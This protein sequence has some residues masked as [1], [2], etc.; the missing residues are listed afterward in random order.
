MR[1]PNAWCQR[2]SSTRAGVDAV[3]KAVTDRLGGLDIVVHNVGGSA[4]KGGGAL[5]LSDED[6]QQALETNL[7]SAVRLDRVDS[8]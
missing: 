4:A 1:L 3:V 5:V 2:T 7:F 6:W 8:I